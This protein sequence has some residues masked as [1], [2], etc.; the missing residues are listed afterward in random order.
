MAGVRR[1]R[2]QRSRGQS[3]RT[4]LEPRERRLRNVQTLALVGLLVVTMGLAGLLTVIG[5]P[6]VVTAPVGLVVYLVGWQ[7][8]LDAGRSRRRSRRRRDRDER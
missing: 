4:A 8:I 7:R 3:P 2:E 6:L 1:G 5:L